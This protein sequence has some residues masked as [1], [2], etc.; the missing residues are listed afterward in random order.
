MTKT[1]IT[2]LI[3]T[4]PKITTSILPKSITT[5]ITIT[6]NDNIDDIP[7]INTIYIIFIDILDTIFN[8]TL[9]NTIHIH[10]KTT[11]NLT[12]KT[13]SHTL[14][15]TH[16]TELNYQKNTFNS[17]TLILYKI[18]TSLIAPFL[19]PIILTIIN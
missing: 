5:P 11:H 16:Y 12:I 15:T 14:D 13:T 7:T 3:N 9:L 1:S 10:T 6:I 18:I 4:S 8:H 19:F 17:L 2:L